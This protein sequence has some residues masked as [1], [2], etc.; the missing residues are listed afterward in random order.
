MIRP[1]LRRFLVALF[2]TAFALNWLWE[3]SQMPAYVE[4]SGRS[5]RETALTCML[6][7][8]GD[9]VLTLFVYCAGALVTWRLRWALRGGWRVYLTA[10]LLGALCAFA[11]EWVA[12]SSAHWSYNERMPEVL[13]AGLWP[14]LQLMLLAPAAFRVAL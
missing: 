12:L 9:A 1:P 10:A 2:V 3:M 8:A 13:G 14:V 11:V 5:W 7:S 4:M 6:A